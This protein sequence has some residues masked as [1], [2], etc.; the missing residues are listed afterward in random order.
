M[1]QTL[2]S[3]DAIETQIAPLSILNGPGRGF[4]ELGEIPTDPAAVEH[5]HLVAE[6]DNE[7]I[8]QNKS[9]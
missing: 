1:I 3:H 4:C 6:V 5:P 8:T 7:T 2:H 9:D